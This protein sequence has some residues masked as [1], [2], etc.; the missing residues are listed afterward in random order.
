[1][2]FSELRQDVFAYSPKIIEIR[3]ILHQNPELSYQE[4]ETAKLVADQ[5]EKDGIEVRRG[6]GGTGVVGV[7]YGRNRNRTIGLRADMDALPVQEQTGL[8]FSSKRDGVMHACGHDTHV[9]MLLGAAHIL[10]KH[11]DELPNNVKFLFQPAE[12]DGGEGGALPMIRDGALEDPHVDHVFGLH[13][14]SDVPVGTF[15]LR[16]GAIMAAP[17]SFKIEVTGRGGHGSLPDQSIDPIYVG[18]Q[19]IS[20]LYGIRSRYMSQTKPLVISVCS[21]HSGTKDNIIPDKL[22]MEGT[23]RTL[24]EDLRT[25]VK[26]KIESM[27]PSIAEAFGASAK[28][29]FKEN[30]YPVTYNDPGITERV[31]GILSRIEGMKV[32]EIEPVM[33]GEDVSRFL[34]KAPGTYY[35]LGTRN[36]SKGLVYPNHNSK[37][38]SDEDYLKFGTLSHVLIAMEPW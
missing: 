5:L 10:A 34:Q 16:G 15:A 31:K 13:I 36:E 9:A 7:L 29:S 12:E 17:D 20:A 19:L 14:V 8:S 21:V 25:Q 6:V 35:F 38:N 11:R 26:S 4:F 23:I 2:D 37:F 18:S 32:V 3:R 28:V 30:A 33:G 27:I 1:M 24:D 22:V